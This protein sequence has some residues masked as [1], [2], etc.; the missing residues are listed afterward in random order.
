MRTGGQA[1]APAL[2]YDAIVIPGGGVRPGGELPPW[3][4]PRMDRALALAGGSY[5]MP[6]SAGTPHRAPPLDEFGY[7]WTEARAGARYLARHGADPARILMEEL[8]Y[9]TIGNAYFSR[10]LHAIP[11]GFQRLLVITSA[12]HMPRTEAVFRWVYE[13]EAP[14][15]PCEVEFESV[16]D[17]G[18]D[19][20]TLLLRTEKEKKSLAAVEHER[21]R[22]RTLA[23][24]HEWLFTRHGAYSWPGECK[25]GSGEV[26]LY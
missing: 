25:Q 2:P 9:D 20:A 23:D 16:P 24:M 6:L 21:P 26:P 13:L 14:G 11:R 10:V 18:I 19:A 17:E 7:P 1:K 3:V 12:F 5:L 8:S 4:K 15:V 22:I